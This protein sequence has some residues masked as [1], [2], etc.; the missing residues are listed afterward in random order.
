MV[1]ECAAVVADYAA[2]DAERDEGAGGAG[3]EEGAPADFVDE[4]EGWEGGEGLGAG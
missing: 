3:E 4:E 2:D 1:F